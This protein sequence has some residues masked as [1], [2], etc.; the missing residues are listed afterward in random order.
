MKPAFRRLRMGPAGKN[1]SVTLR[2]VNAVRFQLRH[3]MNKLMFLA[4]ATLFGCTN[5]ADR[6]L[7]Q[8]TCGGET[9]T[10]RAIDPGALQNHRLYTELT[11]G[12]RPPIRPRDRFVPHRLPYDTDIYG[13]S[14]WKLIDTTLSYSRHKRFHYPRDRVM[15]YLDPNVYSRSDFDA[16]Y[17]CIHAHASALVQAMDTLALGQDYQFAGIVLGNASDFTQRFSAGKT[18]IDIFPDGTIQYESNKP[19]STVGGPVFYNFGGDKVQMP[20]RRI[21]IGDPHRVI[22]TDWHQFRN[23]AGQALDDVFTL[24]YAPN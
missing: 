21:I 5:Q 19:D 7:Y 15:L 24:V 9:L 13:Q 17:Q 2:A 23:A 10:L 8:A 6:T 14:P 20:G 1:E 22:K 4:L 18:N 11:V 12:N 3:L 16:I